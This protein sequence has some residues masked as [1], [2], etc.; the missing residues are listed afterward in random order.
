MKITIVQGPFL[1]VPPLMGGAIEKAFFSLGQ[2]WVRMGHTVT[3]ISRA[4]PDLP[5]QEI[6]S[7]VQHLRVPSQASTRSGIYNKFLDLQYSRRVLKI[8]PPA[9]LLIPHTFFLPTLAGLFDPHHRHGKVFLHVGRFPRGQL[10]FYRGVSRFQFPSSAVAQAAERQAPWLQGRSTVIPYPVHLPPLPPVRPPLQPPFHL[11]YAGRVHP[12][13][14]LHVLLSSIALLPSDLQK[15][16]RLRI[17]GPHE[18]SAGG[19]GQAYLASLKTL[20]QKT[21]ATVIFA[22]PLFDP[23]ALAAEYAAADLFVYP[24][25]ADRGETFGVAPLEALSHGTPVLVSAL[26]CFRDFITPQNGFVFNHRTVHPAQELAAA[27]QGAFDRWADWPLL[28]TAARHT[29]EHFSLET[30]SQRFIKEFE[31]VL[32]EGKNHE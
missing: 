8:L 15:N 14:G 13:K 9:D 17:V 12:E 3:H 22:G 28:S 10:T 19:G 1:P 20:A 25:L 23:A 11:L 2:Y 5:P 31:N 16:I 30:L 6:I 21:S 4:H 29:A 24:S 26:E 18:T 7:G 27:L 32:S